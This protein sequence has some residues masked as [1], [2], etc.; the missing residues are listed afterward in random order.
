MKNPL[1]NR[2]FAVMPAQTVHPVR[3]IARLERATT[4]SLNQLTNHR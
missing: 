1:W 3:R 4:A 2:I